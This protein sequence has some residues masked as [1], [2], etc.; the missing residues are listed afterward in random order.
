V[1]ERFIHF[2]ISRRIALLAIIVVSLLASVY[3]ITTIRVDNDTLK[4]IPQ[5]IK[6][7][8]DYEKLK[9]EFPAPFNILFLADFEQGTLAEKID[10]LRSWSKRFEAIKGV[11]GV[12]DLTKLQVPAK[13]GFLGISGRYAVP[14]EGPVDEESVRS[15]IAGN[16]E[17]SSIFISPDERFLGM[18]IALDWSA[19][20]TMIL[21]TLLSDM[22]RLDARPGLTTYLTSEAAVSYF[23]D[24]AMKRNFVIL[25]PICFL[26]IFLLLYR[27]MRSL[28]YTCASLC[29]VALALAW[30]FGLFGFLKIPFSIIISIVPVIIFPIGVADAIHLLRAYSA[31]R[32]RG[33]SI[34]DALTA[35]YREL[36]TP[37]LLTSLTT[38][39]GFA[40]FAFSNI[41]WNRTFGLFT[42]IAVM[43]CYVFNITLLPLFLSFGKRA[44]TASA[45]TASQTPSR[46]ELMAGRL[47]DV[48]I[49]FTIHSKRWLFM[50]PIL[51]ALLVIG[52]MRGR[53]ENN[54]MMMLPGQNPLRQSDAFISKHFGGTRFFSVALHKRSGKI[55][56]VQDWERIDS[57]VTFIRSRHGVGNVSSLLPFIG[58]VS[59]IL[60]KQEF[61]AAAVAVVTS[62]G[63]LFGKT[64]GKAVSGFISPDRTSTRIQITCKSDPSVKTLDIAREIET[65]STAH[66]DGYDILT[67]GPA[68]IS[69]GMSAI[70]VNT[71]IVSLI[72][73]IIPV[74]LSLL[75]F[76][77][78]PRIAVYCTVP[79]VLLTAFV[80]SM[81]GLCN[82]TINMIT[83]IIMNV[84]IGIGIDYAIHFISGYRFI[85]PDQPDTQSALIT[86][87]RRKGPP[88]LFNAVV[89]GTGFCVLVFSD[90]PP[91]RDF[92]VMV[93]ISM[94]V[95]VFFCMFVPTL[96]INKLGLQ[97]RVRT[98]E[99]P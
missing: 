1:T 75:I 58:S 48:F 55:D 72:T 96:L 24:K 15:L 8:V 93:F 20:R 80:Y 78:S 92:G 49:N 5:D 52:F 90:F 98:G 25:L 21:D 29:A 51:A 46:E 14:Q 63:G 34:A 28:L 31:N 22:K 43:L 84:C 41:S 94:F 6:L 61:S 99:K 74:F 53:I 9:R 95:A 32:S 23:I 50:I 66:M 69:D 81:L 56:S 36:L 10:S 70:L 82:I 85:R 83:A 30:T 67:S 42:G 73:T 89:V 4:A 13:S 38:F 2:L 59:R 17:F 62:T 88:I 19:D 47:W 91:I 68:I 71:I 3:Y 60:S 40:S 86:T 37:C 18:I 79:I 77:R 11:G 26:I 12:T 35:T 7:R 87:I 33:E 27:V 65:Y 39:A 16:R 64:F 76:F 57:L 45:V 54:F 97:V 44:I